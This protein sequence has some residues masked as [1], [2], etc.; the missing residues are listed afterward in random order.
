MGI[1][2]SNLLDPL[3][4]TLISISY[5][6][7]SFFVFREESVINHLH[8]TFHAQPDLVFLLMKMQH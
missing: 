2:K 6:I 4:S 8:S 3:F 5:A 1:E 7:L